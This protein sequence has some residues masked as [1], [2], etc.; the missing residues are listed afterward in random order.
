V[1]KCDFNLEDVQKVYGGPEG[2]LW[3]LI[4]GEQIHVGGWRSSKEL[5]DK[6]G[7]KKGMKVLDL[8]SALGAGLRFLVRNYGVE[9]VGIDATEHMINE[10]R[11][12]TDAEGMS[13]QIQMKLADVTG[14]PW[15][16]KTFDIVWGEDAWCYVA[17]KEKLVMEAYR[18]L[19]KGGK[20]AFT[21]WIEGPAGL[22]DSDAAR[23]NTFM[24]FPY[25]ESRKG[26]EKILGDAGFK[27]EVSDDLTADFADHM[28]LYIKMLTDQLMFDALKI[29]GNDMD[30][31]SRMGG[32]MLFMEEMA[33]KGGFGRCRMIAVK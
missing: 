21:D 12:R 4:M 19:G 25:M 8:C 3:E 33:S 17:D 10:A 24:K 29:I 26:Y 14:I 2:E 16:E 18:V 9:G 22:S 5:A 1:K 30:L 6:S 13:S 7:V 11:K 23:I 20:I 31:F 28:G 32:E 27:I 15:P